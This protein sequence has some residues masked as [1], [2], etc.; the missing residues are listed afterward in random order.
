MGFFRKLLGIAPKIDHRQ[1]IAEGAVIIDVRSAG[2][3]K[4]GHPKG[5]VN[6][7]LDRIADVT[8]KYK[9]DQKIVLCCKSGMRAG[10]AKSQLK[11]LGYSDICN[12]GAWQNV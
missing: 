5:A 6:I 4:S 11:S 2:E 10:S 7:P 12:V 3:F 9:K 1:W 8:R